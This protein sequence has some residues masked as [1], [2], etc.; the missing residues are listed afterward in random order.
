M[1]KQDS[2]VIKSQAVACP[3]L[4]AN[5][6]SCPPELA[7][8]QHES[9][10]FNF[11]LLL[12][13]RYGSRLAPCTIPVAEYERLY[14]HLDVSGRTLLEAA[15]QLD[16]NAVPPVYVLQPHTGLSTGADR[17]ATDAAWHAQFAQPLLAALGSAAPHAGLTASREIAYT[18]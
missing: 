14:P 11:L 5:V 1:C 7:R 6:H 15:Y 18:G 16:E 12:G 9:P 2:Q 3:P 8:C 10:D 17:N 4:S 13:D